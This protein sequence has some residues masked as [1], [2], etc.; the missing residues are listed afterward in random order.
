MK[1]QFLGATTTV[2]GSRYLLTHGNTTVLVDCGLFQGFKNLRLKNWAEFPVDLKRLDAVLLT[3]AHL[4]HSGYLPVLVKQGYPGPIYA[5]RPTIDLCNIL[6]PDSGFL[7]E[8]EARLANKRG[9]SKH[10]PALPLYTAE[11]AKRCLDSFKN[12][13]W[14][15]PNRIS[16][17]GL[18]NLEFEYH[19]AGHLLGAASVHVQTE[20]ASI[21]FSG[22]LGRRTDPMIR[23]P[24]ARF[25]ADYLVI[26]STYGDRS[27]PK[28]DPEKEIGAIVN[29]TFGRNG[30]L[31]IP[32]FAVGR[33]QLVLYYLLQLKRRYAIP[34]IPIYLNSPM[35]AQA[36][37]AFSAHADELKIAPKELA[38]I[39][40]SVR[41]I[42]SQ[43]ESIA[44][45]EKAEPSIIIAAS[46]MAT[47]GRVLHHLKRIAPNPQNTILFAGFQAGGTRGDLMVRGADSIK[48]HGEQ[49]PVRAEV[50][51]LENLSAHADSD[52]L[53]EWIGRLER[54]PKRVFITH[55]EPEAADALRRRIGDDLG[56]EADVPEYLQEY[57][58]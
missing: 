42:S 2:T 20:S 29:R 33:A 44:L 38:E 6:L 23:V 41:I 37:K 49:W 50:I 47:G 10:K 28:T 8:E 25:G 16:R 27:H 4:D 46:G 1:I 55:G 48:I 40:K 19:P 34:D 32:S 39:W 22:D 14:K 7:Q 56:I 26:E 24:E 53:L 36:N 52:E 30:I 58:L 5:T 15:K 11:D 35:A 57:E 12:V 9:F 18:G 31:L 21:A 17:K 54:K 45:N 51:N 13:P 3:H 43:E